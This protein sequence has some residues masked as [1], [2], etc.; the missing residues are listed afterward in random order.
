MPAAARESMALGVTARE[1]CRMASAIPGAARRHTASVASGVT[2]LG[3]KPVPP[4][5]TI[6]AVSA[7]SAS[8]ISAA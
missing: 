7:P 2:S 8:R 5:V 6:R 4:L 3:E 1:A